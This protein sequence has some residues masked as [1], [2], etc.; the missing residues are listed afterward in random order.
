M[1][2]QLVIGASGFLGSH[3]TRRLV[4]RGEDVRVL[5]RRT[6]STRGIDGL[7]VERHYGDI[8]DGDAVRAA[9]AGC[10]VVYY[11][12]VDARAWLRDATPLW[13]T[14]VE[15]LHRVLD[16]VAGVELQ[17]FVFTSSIATIGIAAHG[18]ATEEL[19][20][21]WLDRAGEYVRTRVAAENLVLRYHRERGLPAVAMCVSNTYGSGDW[22]PTPHG[23]LVAAAVRGKLPFYIDGAQ[24]EVVG[25]RDAADALILAGE[26]GTPGE[27]YIISERF[28]TAREIYRTACAAVGVEP[29]RI[30]VPIQALAA[31]AVPSAW[32]ARIRRTDTRLT[33][34][35]IRLMHVMSPMN[36][37]KAERELGWRPAP[38][39]EALAEAAEFF[40]GARRRPA[41][42][43][44]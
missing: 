11:C 39:T 38:T 41:E 28:M 7:P 31:A 10:D 4:E 9:V 34:L 29:P 23:G 37:T 8:F 17:R 35:S 25:V 2:K 30:G 5:I 36:H 32:L 16:V 13:R 3:V 44:S 20:N 12:V 33:P 43:R 6:S 40:V 22:L 21:N 24:A 18:K 15:G 14:N 19:P 42:D 1:G 27:R 26:R